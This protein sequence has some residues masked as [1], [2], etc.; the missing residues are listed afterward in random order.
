[1]HVNTMIIIMRAEGAAKLRI[2]ER[3]PCSETAS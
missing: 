1:M 3:I 2:T